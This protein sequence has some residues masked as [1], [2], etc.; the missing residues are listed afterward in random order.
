[1][2]LEK[3]S[4]GV[5]GL[6]PDSPFV[7]ISERIRLSDN[8]PYHSTI[9]NNEAGDT[10]DGTDGIVPYESSHI[11]GTRHQTLYSL[12]QDQKIRYKTIRL[13]SIYRPFF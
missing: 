10:P 2:K 12:F 7:R 1:M 11:D 5:D 13:R 9:G 3:M 4:T 8:I 6:K